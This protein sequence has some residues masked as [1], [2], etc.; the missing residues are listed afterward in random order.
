MKRS[1]VGARA[2]TSALVFRQLRAAGKQMQC[3]RCAQHN[4]VWLWLDGTT[5]VTIHIHHG[6][7]ATC[8]D[9]Q[10]PE[11]ESMSARKKV[12]CRLPSHEDSLKHTRLRGDWHR[13]VFKRARC[14]WRDSGAGAGL[15][16]DGKPCDTSGVHA[17]RCDTEQP[18]QERPQEQRSRASQHAQRA[19]TGKNQ[20][21]R[22]ERLW[23]PYPQRPSSDSDMMKIPARD[24]DPLRPTRP[25]LSTTPYSQRVGEVSF[26]AQKTP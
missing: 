19:S 16:P 3:V 1:D 7:H 25:P 13:T 17:P 18:A 21:L 4:I 20:L 14:S 15:E 9:K 6:A 11:S 23:Q 26:C 12:C 8:V 10:P 22:L 24:T 2:P 5:V